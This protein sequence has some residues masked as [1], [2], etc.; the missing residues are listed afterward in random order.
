MAVLV[1]PARSWAAELPDL[2]S[3]ELDE[4]LD[5]LRT[6]FIRRGFD[7]ETYIARSSR[8]RRAEHEGGKAGA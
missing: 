3:W 1:S 5:A 6:E 2:A 7:F 4:L 8:S